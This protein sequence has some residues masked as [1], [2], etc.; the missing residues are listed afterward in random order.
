[1]SVI[2]QRDLIGSLRELVAATTRA[3]CVARIER[4]LERLFGD[5]GPALTLDL[6]DDG[7]QRG[8]DQRGS[9]Q[10]SAGREPRFA[11]RARGRELGHIALSSAD[12]L[13]ERTRE[14]LSAFAEH[15]AI[16][17]DNARLLEDRDR[18]ARRDPLTGLLNRSEFQDM[19]AATVA[20]TERDPSVTLSLA[21]FDLDHFKSVNESAGHSTGDRLLRATAAALTAVSRSTDVVF[22]IGGDEFALLLPDCLSEDANAIASRAADAISRLDGSVGASWGVATIPTDAE[23]REALLAVADATMYE[24]KGLRKTRSFSSGGDIPNRLEVASRLALQLT[25][26]NDPREIAQTVVDELHSAFGY[27]LAAIHRLDADQ[28]LR[29]L[30]ASGHLTEEGLE[31]LATE[32]PMTAGVNGRAVQAGEPVVVDDT[33]TSGTHAGSG[34]K[35]GAGSELSLPILIA[36]RV[37]GV[38]N[39]EQLATHGFDES[40]VMLA[41]AV[42]A[43]TAAALHRCELV[44]EL[45]SSISAAVG[46]LRDALMRPRS[47]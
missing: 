32:Q 2:S 18:R 31:W 4:D 9:D 14:Q 6:H 39:L 12:E 41:E 43:Q 26:S 16:A 37:W 47:S 8:S 20:R 19:L 25:Q 38:L 44:G 34:P 45:E 35:L 15:A 21:V 13:D 28:M 1:M 5:L 17:L 46:A 10:T 11:L 42:V 27:Y 40:D 22:R 33:H 3:E 7:D 36:D 29:L 30:A 23:T 24:R